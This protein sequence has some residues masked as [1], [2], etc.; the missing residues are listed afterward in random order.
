MNKIK[1]DKGDRKQFLL[2]AIVST[3]FIVVS[4][5]LL[6]FDFADDSMSATLY[7]VLMIAS[8]LFLPVICF[9]MWVM[10]F[11]SYMYLK[12]L[13]KYGYIVPENKKDYDNDIE[14]L[15]NGEIKSYAE[16]SRE[17]MA[18]A[19]IS[20]VVSLGMVAFAVFYFV[21]FSHM[22]ENVAFLGFV[23]IFIAILW[24]VFGVYFFRQ[25]SRGLYRDDVEY[26]SP[27]KKRNHLVE[28]IVTIIVFVAITVVV[29]NSMYSM[30]K[31]VERSKEMQEQGMDIGVSFDV[32]DM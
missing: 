10:F 17:S 13:D 31:Y 26:N 20:W 25:R 22:L 21:R 18:L 4:L 7:A 2:L 3:I 12:R 6:Q 24:A 28:G 15:I 11:D 14:K 5:I 19:S 23:S 29:A 27:L 30:A 32:I 16:P 9:A 1:Y 8:V